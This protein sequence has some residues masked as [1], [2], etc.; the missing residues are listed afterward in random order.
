LA[1]LA[2]PLLAA[3]RLGLRARLTGA[4]LLVAAYVPL[5]GAGPSIQRAGVMGAAGLLAALAGRPASRT[6][7]LL[8]AAA[9]TLVLNPRPAGAAPAAAVELRLGSPLAVAG[10]YLAL[11][12][13]LLLARR[14]RRT[15]RARG[16]A[17]ALVAAALAAA[18]IAA[19]VGAHG[20]P[21]PPLP[22]QLRVS[23]L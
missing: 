7:A 21:L 15:R 18:V 14:T 17:L 12:V 10:A 19:R 3:L 16:P 4:L 22:G 13:V 20:A 9:A 11:G 8:L 6:Y 1:A 5:A 23:F 2:L